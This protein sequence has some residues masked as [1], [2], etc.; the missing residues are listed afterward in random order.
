MNPSR[1]QL[2]ICA[3]SLQSALNADLAG[4]DRVE[5]CENLLE[6]GTTPSYGTIRQACERLSLQVL[7]IIRPR[8]GDFVYSDEEFQTMQYDIELC[9]S[10]GCA[11]VVFGILDSKGEIDE[12][13]CARLI[14]LASP[15][16]VVFHRAFDRI[17]DLVDGLETLIRLGFHRVLTSGGADAVGQ[18]LPM[19]KKLVSLAAGRIEILLG[20]GVLE[21]NALLFMEATGA[22]QVHA[23]LRTTMPNGTME[24]PVTR[25]RALRIQLDGL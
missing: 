4:A 24:S 18:G 14:R 20:G 10:L 3:G 7:P 5:L 12:D 15:M 9:K 11:G 8:G 23:S 25:I 22:N 6:G 19:L 17:P 13:R 2:E 21:D 1:F 16:Q